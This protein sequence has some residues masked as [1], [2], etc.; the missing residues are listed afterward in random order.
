[1]SSHLFMP[2]ASRGWLRPLTESSRSFFTSFKLSS[3]SRLSLT[4]WVAFAW[5][6]KINAILVREYFGER[7]MGAAFGAVLGTIGG[8]ALG[9]VT[10]EEIERLQAEGHF[11]P[12]SMG[13]KIEAMI[14]FL[15]AHPTGRGLI[16]TPDK[17]LAALDGQSSADVALRDVPSLAR[18]E[19]EHIQRVLSSVDG[20]I[21]AAAR[22][23]NMHRRTLQRKL[24]KFPP[25]N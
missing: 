4:S 17:I 12:G 16:T 13:P 20:N 25:R 9:A 6:Q 19:W 10:L 11:P 21:S 8:V 2:S 1:M 3:T 5:S 22:A 14:A 15:E 18:V 23:L 24:N 7:I